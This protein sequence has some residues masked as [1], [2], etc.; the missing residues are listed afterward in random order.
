MPHLH[1][2]DTPW[3]LLVT[4]FLIVLTC[5]FVVS[6]LYVMHTTEPMDGKEGM[7]L[8]DITYMFHGDKKKT[9]LRKQVLGGM[10]KYFAEG[11]ELKNLTQEDQADI[12]AVI[13]WNDAGATE[14]GYWD[15]EKKQDDKNPRAIINILYNNSCLDCHAPDA[16]MKG[17][18]RN[19][20]LDTFEGISKFTKPDPG[21]DE[22]RLLMLSH[23]HLLGMGMM[24][25]LAGAAVASTLWPA[26]LR[27]AL[28]VGGML[29]ILVDIFGWW[30]VKYGG[31]AWSP[32]VMAG[33]MLM[34]VC[35]GASVFAAMYDLWLRKAPR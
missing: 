26:K 24:F 9:T 1:S 16:T 20:P 23:V 12:D 13:A 19:S 2:L 30:G 31:A 32:V 10:K 27:S 8:D 28:I 5:G 29:S 34:A 18:K 15:P 3:K 7:S 17:N 4:F 22:G 6:E 21:M 11:G 14:A 33:G 35:F 25:L